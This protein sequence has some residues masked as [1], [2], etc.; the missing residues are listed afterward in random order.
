MRFRQ[1]HLDFHTSEAIEGIGADFSQK[2]FQEALKL[3]HVNSITVFSKCHHGWAYHP[4]KANETHPH[5]S[6][7][8]LGEQ[9]KAAHEIGVN[10]P[11]Y[12]SAGLDEKEARRRPDWL[13]RGEN[14]RMQWTDS[15]LKPGFHLFCF[16]TPYLDVLCAQIEEV[17]QN[18]D[19]DGIFLDI[20]SA[21]NCVCRH[22]IDT[23]VAE[24][25]DPLNANH[26]RDL[27]ERVYENY[28]RRTNEAVHK[29]KPHLPVFH[30]GG[31][32]KRG[33]RDLVHYN[34]HLEL[35]SLPTGGWGYDHFPLSARYSAT[36]GMDYLGMTGKFHTTWGEFGGYKHPNA[37]RYEAAL[38]IANGAK[39]GVGDQLHPSGLMD[40][41]TY[42]LIGAAYAE[43]EQK[44]QWCE[45]AEPI[46]DIALLSVEASEFANG[47]KN[48]PRDGESD[49]GAV[50]MLLEGHY[51]FNVI[52]T[53]ADFN[54]YKVIVLPDSIVMGS[55]IKSKLD[56]F[57]A[58]GGKVLA[59]GKSGL[60]EALDSFTLNLGAVYVRQSEFRPNYLRPNFPVEP[61]QNAAFIMY[62]QSNVI[63]VAENG[64]VLGE[65]EEPF[66]NRE[67][68]HFCSHQ[69]T[70]SNGKQA[71]PGITQGP[72]GIY[73]SWP[74]FKDYST[75]GSLI[76]KKVVHF[77]LDKLLGS[78]KTLTT[79]LGAQ[80]ITTLTRQAPANR[81]VLH[82]LYASPVKRGKGIEVIEDIVD[83]HEVDVAIRNLPKVTAVRTQPSGELQEYT[84]N[85]EELQFTVPRLSC[86]QIVE[87]QL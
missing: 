70:P 34:T 56:A 45:G 32:I 38:A 12:I 33:R 78:D 48:V 8:L 80:G 26:V 7:D 54:A 30:N 62:E 85:A 1:V 36:L 42:A 13:V 68:K 15:F 81:Y 40:T 22:C 65:R 10:T 83:I 3:G 75:T 58:G 23:L 14:E 20:V 31:H 25:N 39:V 43:V 57:V 53:E 63:D 87:I 50:R 49:A 35:E 60:N 79:S 64:I 71:G 4:S 66:F 18:Y 28:A 6:F 55:A 51:L 11:V 61:L 76:L 47:S 2:Q 84:Q 37:L 5:L 77:A 16:N 46:A 72:D 59:T 73:I 27:A 69:H 86:H 9:I 41:A 67:W 29:H 21:Q 52:D 19:T 17:V 82:L 24:G 74:V 44:E